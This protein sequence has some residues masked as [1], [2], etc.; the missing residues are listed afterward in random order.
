MFD[1]EMTF[2]LDF[3]HFRSQGQMQSF[4]LSGTNIRGLAVKIRVFYCDLEKVGQG[5]TSKSAKNDSCGF[6]L[7]FSAI[8]NI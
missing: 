5:Q 4:T 3:D 1:L 7:A 6:L 2:D 8:L